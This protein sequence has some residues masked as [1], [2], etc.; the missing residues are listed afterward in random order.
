MVSTFL[1]CILC[2]STFSISVSFGWTFTSS[3]FL[4]Y[5]IPRYTEYSQTACLAPWI[6]VNI[7]VALFFRCG[8]TL[9]GCIIIN[10]CLYILFIFPNRFMPARKMPNTFNIERPSP[11]YFRWLIRSSALGDSVGVIMLT[12]A[13]KHRENTKP[14]KKGINQEE[15]QDYKQML[16]FVGW[17]SVQ[18]AMKCYD[19]HPGKTTVGI[20]LSD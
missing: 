20:E 7:S 13:G 1:M 17:S 19:W 5:I 2:S 9:S 3:G 18:C 11:C 15:M 8:F 4:F 16:S 10:R 14:N 6:N 12:K